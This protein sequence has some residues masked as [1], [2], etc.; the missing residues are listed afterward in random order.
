M[1]TFYPGPSKVYPQVPRYVQEAYEAGVLS[2]NHRSL[3]FVA[4]SARAIRQVKEKLRVPDDYTVLYA[5]SATE[6]WEI[7]SQSLVAHASYHVY[8]GAFGEKWYRYARQ[9]QPQADGYAFERQQPLQ[10]DDLHPPE[11]S[12]IIC[13]TQNETSNGTAMDKATLTEIRSRFADMLI[14]VDAT[15][16]LAGVDLPMAQADVWYA[17]VQK[18]FGLP[19]GMALLICSPRA[20]AQAQEVGERDHYNS[21]LLM[22]EKMQ[23]WQTTHTPNVLAIYLLMR[24]LEARKGI[25]EVDQ[26]TQQRYAQWVDFLSDLDGLRLLIDDPAVRSR[27]VIP[28]ESDSETINRLRDEAN[29]VGITLGNGYGDLKPTTLRIANFPAMEDDEIDQLKKFLRNDEGSKPTRRGME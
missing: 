14:A 8:N 16:S 26:Q 28:I 18:C 7:I 13:L 19:A 5:S 10:V 11:G 15:S 4:L 1:I 12:E 22:Q 25:E 6:C 23:D 17:S 24:T 21:L 3:E 29:A 20:L 9:L 2:I 27:T